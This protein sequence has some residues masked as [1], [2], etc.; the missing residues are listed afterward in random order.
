[1][2]LVHPLL[3]FISAVLNQGF[4]LKCTLRGLRQIL[5]SLLRVVVHHLAEGSPEVVGLVHL[6]AWSRHFH[7]RTLELLRHAVL[8][9]S[10]DFSFELLTSFSL[11]TSLALFCSFSRIRTVR[12]EEIVD[13]LSKNVRVG[14]HGVH[15]CPLFVR[16]LQHLMHRVAALNLLNQSIFN[17]TCIGVQESRGFSTKVLKDFK[18]FSADCAEI[19]ILS[20]TCS[21]LGCCLHQ[22][23]DFRFRIR[24][25]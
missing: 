24:L 9:L 13:V 12:T 3:L 20:L 18:T 16:S 11:L 4:C 1:M 6:L 15:G 10:L 17:G 5:P 8:F 21:L 7:F 25:G 19:L 22:L 2:Y 23:A 14:Q